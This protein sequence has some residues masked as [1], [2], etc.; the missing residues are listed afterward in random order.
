MRIPRRI[1]QW[2]H[3]RDRDA[4]PDSIDRFVN[5]E[6]IPAISA[7]AG[8][9]ILREQQRIERAIRDHI[10]NLYDEIASMEAERTTMEGEITDLVDGG[11]CISPQ[12]GALN[13]IR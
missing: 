8:A 3:L 2:L 13:E 9:D 6:S 7:D 10:L 5:G 1:L 4:A 11:F 12:D